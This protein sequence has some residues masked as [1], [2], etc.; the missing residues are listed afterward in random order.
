MRKIITISRELGSGGRE[1]GKRLADILNLNY[2]DS[3]IVEAVAKQTNLDEQYVKG[4]LEGGV[5]NYPVTFG[6]SFSRMPYMNNSAMLIAKQ[7]N[8][9]KELVKDTDCVIVGR[10][11]DAVLSDL[12]PFRIFVYADMK[13]KIARCKSRAGGESMTEKEIEREIKRVDKSRKSA[14]DLYAA[15]A[16]GDKAGYDLCINTTGIEIRDIVPLIAEYANCYF[17]N[18]N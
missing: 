8:I 12:K 18:G 11:A 5:N 17:K 3:E 13:S 16:W 15:H 9:I 14:H 10:G 6:R 2:L 1:I 4:K 7:H